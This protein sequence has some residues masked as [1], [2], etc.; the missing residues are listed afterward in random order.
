MTFGREINLP[1]KLQFV[2]ESNGPEIGNAERN[3]NKCI[4]FISNTLLSVFL[5]LAIDPVN[6]N[7]RNANPEQIQFVIALTTNSCSGTV[8]LNV[9]HLFSL[10]QKISITCNAIGYPLLFGCPFVTFIDHSNRYRRVL[11][12][13]HSPVHTDNGELTCETKHRIILTADMR[14][15]AV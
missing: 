2:S 1:E 7:A 15:G 10:L 8:T 5:C 3:V 12:F 4:I 9:W 11:S 14:H 6:R 13:I